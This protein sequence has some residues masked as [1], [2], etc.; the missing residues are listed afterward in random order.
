M[1]YDAQSRW[2]VLLEKKD[3]KAVWSAINWK[4]KMEFRD[5]NE[6]RPSDEMFRH[7]F[8]KLLNPSSEGIGITVPQTDGP[9][10]SGRNQKRYS[11]VSP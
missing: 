4:G 6:S 5:D 7:H 1:A 3:L 11:E 10:N 9:D 8:E 2:Q